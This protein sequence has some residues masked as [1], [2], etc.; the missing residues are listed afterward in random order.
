MTFERNSAASAAATHGLVA[1]ENVASSSLVSRS[2]SQKQGQSYIGLAFFFVPFFA[3]SPLLRYNM[4]RE[5]A[6]FR[7]CAIRVRFCRFIPLKCGQSKDVLSGGY[8]CALRRVLPRL[9][10]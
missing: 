4:P 1:N 5:Q 2:T 10:G 9:R 8:A 7:L 6:D 3:F